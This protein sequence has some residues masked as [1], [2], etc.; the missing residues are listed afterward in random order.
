MNST[1][2]IDHRSAAPRLLKALL[3]AAALALLASAVW[4]YRAQ[5]AQQRHK[6]EDE[7]ASVAQ[8]K[9]DQIT[10]WRAERLANASVLTESPFFVEAVE[11]AMRGAAGDVRDE[12]RRRFQTLQRYDHYA[13]VLLVDPS[14][15]VRLS[16]TADPTVHRGYMTAQREAFEVR[17]PVF[18]EL[19]TESRDE[20]PH[21]SIVAPL[22]GRGHQ[23]GAPLAAVVLVVDAS[24]LLFP[25][26]RRWPTDSLSAETLLVRRDGADV[27]Y[28]NDLRHRA[29][30]ALTLRIPLDRAD[31]PAVMAVTGTR[32]VVEGRDYRGTE[33]L[34]VLQ[35]IPESAWFMV[36]KIDMAE[37][38]AEWRFRSRLLLT[39]ML[40]LVGLSIVAWV[41]VGQFEKRSR[42]QILYES[43]AAM[44]A[45]TERH[46][47]I[48]AAVGDGVIATDAQGRVE[49]I[50]R[51]AE[52]LTGWSSPDARGRPLAEVFRVLHERTRQEMENPVGIAVRERRT[53]DVPDDTLLISRG[54]EERP[55]TH[56][57]API[58]S[59]SG[60]VT[61]GVLVFRD[62]SLQRRIEAD[63][64]HAQKME[65]VGR[66]AGGVAHDFNNMLAAILGNVELAI[67]NENA[68][69]PVH[70]EL[71]EIRK[72][73]ERAAVVTR[74]LLGFARKQMTFPRVLDLNATVDDALKML[75]RLIGEDVAIA[76]QPGP[77][78]WPVKIDPSQIDQ[79]L[80]NLVLNARDAI[81]GIGHVTIET[82]NGVF[83]AAYC[84][85]HG[86]YVP[87]E[88]VR[89]AVSDDGCGMPKAVLDRI[90]EPFF[91]SKPVG[92][93]TGLGLA[94][95]YG[96]VT[97]NRGFI[98]VY[99]EPGH[100][101]TF[102]V[103]LPRHAD[104]SD[105]VAPAPA[106]LPPTGG[107]ETVL[108]VEDEPAVLGMAAS[109]LARLGYT[110]LSAST[111][112]EAE[113]LT[114]HYNG[115]I[116]L[117]LTDVVMPDMTGPDLAVRLCGIR[118]GMRVL[119]MSGY[120][121]NV[122]AQ[123][124]V[125]DDEVGLVD[126]PFSLSDLAAKVRSALVQTGPADP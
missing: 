63:L 36:A 97:Q 69:R 74:Q 115:E 41:A 91:T 28:L 92:K 48:L 34:A 103:Y 95:V 58:R 16:A 39:M 9:V 54:G 66:L 83:D 31:V 29:H 61:G 109:M 119:F 107:D 96:I 79:I 53:V 49:L 85:T 68:A 19:H 64:R 1:T 124:S 72:A 4:F 20:R 44:R 21:L 37:A 81:A 32:G 113:R 40:G 56:S 76:W 51:V 45:M 3:A 118:P 87:G 59:D 100:G 38:F 55:I 52:E 110:V 13:D 104:V 22:Y 114:R 57:A 111:P 102:K 75:R 122:I 62:Q 43:E 77:D 27:L 73:A 33:V 71:L 46:G 84:A 26:V 108:V 106:T 5:D 99:S 30:T 86:G 126:K 88:Y 101:S 120:T 7:L 8:L 60:D 18:T 90:F 14:G 89:L 11:R 12:L 25:M 93:G 123:R 23:S 112:A 65:S 10:K 42:Y 47:L 24:D 98:N 94:T 50:N 70:D 6:T 67:G 117:L 121:A 15:R 2:R 35:P 80:A 78:L 125:R 82:G 105:A 17:R 116:E